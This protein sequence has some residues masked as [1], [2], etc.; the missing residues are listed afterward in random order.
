MRDEL[1]MEIAAFWL[2]MMRHI[3]ILI[4]FVVLRANKVNCGCLRN[5]REVKFEKA[6]VQT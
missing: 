5:K 1:V 3:M 4:S 6:F 2:V